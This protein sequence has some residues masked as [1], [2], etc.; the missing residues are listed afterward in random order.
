M[1][2]CT[3]RSDARERAP[4]EASQHTHAISH[5]IS[6]IPAPS[7][8]EWGLMLGGGAFG[9]NDLFATWPLGEGPSRICLLFG[10]R[11]LGVGWD[12]RRVLGGGLRD[13]LMSCPMCAAL[14]CAEFRLGSR[15]GAT[16]A[17]TSC[18]VNDGASLRRA[19]EAEGPAGPGCTEA[20]GRFQCS[21]CA[22]VVGQENASCRSE[23]EA[24]PAT[25]LGPQGD[26]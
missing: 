12:W 3:L 14:V 5:P 16:P 24:T 19:G 7:R 26:G 20:E 8:I 2:H 10:A 21:V 4:A 6:L 17:K 15:F 9:D 11:L 13:S 23:G 18:P 25:M 1:R 22:G